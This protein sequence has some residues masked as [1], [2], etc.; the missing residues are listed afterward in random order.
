MT[1]WGERAWATGAFGLSIVSVGTM[2]TRGWVPLDE[3]TIM[4][5][6]RAVASGYVPHADFAYPYTG[7]LPYL[8]ALAVWLLGDGMTTPRLLLFAAFAAWLP[9]VWVLARRLT[10]A[11]IA[12]AVVLIAAWW[13][14]LIYPA[15]MPTWYLLF[16][17]TWSLLAVARWAE[18]GKRRWLVLAG[19]MAGAAVAVKQTG[20][21]TVV[22]TAL[23]V[24]AFQQAGTLRDLAGTSSTLNEARV[25]V[26]D[27]LVVALLAAAAVVPLIIVLRRGVLSGEMLVIGAPMLAV[28][29]TLLNGDRHD[30]LSVR[31]D[32]RRLLAAWGVLSVGV[33]VPVVGLVVW[34]A[35]HNAL[36]ALGSGA[37]GGIAQT[38]R[39]TERTLAG[40]PALI[41][42]ALPLLAVM[43]VVAL[44]RLRVQRWIAAAIV[45][46]AVCLAA[47][48][49]PVA[50]RAVW[51]FA[52]LLVPAGAIYLFALTRRSATIPNRD[53]LVALGAATALL[54]LNQF[55][56]SAPNY[57]GYVAPL[58][59]L[60]AVAIAVVPASSVGPPADR[61]TFIGWLRTTTARSPFALILLVAFGGWFHRI[62]D[63][64]GVGYGSIWRDNTHRLPGVSGGIGVTAADSVRY[65]RVTALL[66]AH[67]GPESFVAGPE[68]PELYVL[69]GTRRLVH[70]P[71]LL[72]GGAGDSAPRIATG[73]DTNAV[74]AVAINHAPLFLPAPDSAFLA[75]LAARYPFG[76][77]VD[78]IEIRWR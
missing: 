1:R 18:T 61:L 64:H 54:G 2:L 68:L 6:A 69:T 29:A 20:A 10:E 19:V 77:R 16:L 53:L 66:A 73:V 63:V 31:T 12:A 55:P 72:S 21:Y 28:L 40:A 7:A 23:G 33:L 22:G 17:T 67:A 35:A 46:A 38:V 3:G 75:W 8:N 48:T 44:P 36:G 51:N 26:R 24:L 39:V 52:V 45:T 65:A 37:L 47:A 74:R 78:H 50:Y 62:G 58:G 41:V 59:I 5:S 14:L 76:E 27:R 49:F 13:S 34:Y 30:I 60:L 25:Q 56:Y 15:A 9:A 11:P 70:Q 42:T 4:L 71:Y 43:L 32:R 57:F